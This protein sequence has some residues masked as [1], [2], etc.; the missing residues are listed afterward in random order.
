[1]SQKVQGTMDTVSNIEVNKDTVYIRSNI[2]RVETE[3]FV[4]WEYDEVQY[5]KDEY[6]AK[7]ADEKQELTGV[8]DDVVQVLVAKGVV[9]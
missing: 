7:I 6:I 4:G 1:M 8:V 9:Y 5:D 3:D 2:V